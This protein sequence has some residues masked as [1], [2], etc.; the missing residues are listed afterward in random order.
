PGGHLGP[1]RDRPRPG[2]AGPR[3]DRDGGGRG[4]GRRPPG[5]GRG[6]GD[7]RRGEHGLSPPGSGPRERGGRGRWNPCRHRGNLRLP[8]LGAGAGNPETRPP[9][10]ATSKIDAVVADGHRD[11]PW[12]RQRLRP[13]VGVEG[14]PAAREE[15]FA[16]WR[17]FLESLAEDRPS[18]FVIE[19]LHW[20]DE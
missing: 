5:A 19:D 6:H 10:V 3:R 9:E 1:E 12:L 16:A 17:T 20:A 4:G 14:P 15:N 18:V 11:A 13:L 2:S 8:G 7:G